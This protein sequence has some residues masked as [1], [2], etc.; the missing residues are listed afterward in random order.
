MV[1]RW[2]VLVCEVGGAGE[3]GPQRVPGVFQRN[4]FQ[5]GIWSADFGFRIAD[6]GLG[7]AEGGTGGLGTGSFA[8]GATKGLLRE[9]ERDGQ[10]EMATGW[11]GVFLVQGGVF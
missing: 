6:C 9:G 5:R 8:V 10:R 2:C 3:D 1:L 4:W 7:T 11:N